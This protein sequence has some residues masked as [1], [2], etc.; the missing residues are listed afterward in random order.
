MTWLLMLSQWFNRANEIPRVTPETWD[1]WDK[2]FA[3]VWN[4]R[5]WKKPATV[6]KM[7]WLAEIG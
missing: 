4:N 3:Q 1:L 2:S 7:A 5:N 6:K